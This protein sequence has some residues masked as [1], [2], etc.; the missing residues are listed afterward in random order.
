MHL[1]FGARDPKSD[2]LYERELRDWLAD[3]SLSRLTTAFS[4]V[5]GPRLH[6]GSHPG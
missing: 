4:R 5:N 1:F 6:P 2:F 3:G